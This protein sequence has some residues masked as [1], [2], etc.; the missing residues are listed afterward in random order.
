MNRDITIIATTFYR[1]DD[2]RAYRHMRRTLNSWEQN[3]VMGPEGDCNLHIADDGSAEEWSSPVTWM[4]GRV[5][6]SRQERR[7]VGASLN[8][9]IRQLKTDIFAYFVDDWTLDRELDITPMIDLLNRDEN[10]GMIRLG[11][12]HPDL[13]GTV[14]IYRPEGW[15]LLLERHHY[16]YGMRP[17]LYHRRF[18]E[19]YGLFKEGCSAN[20]CESAKNADFKADPYGP[21]ILYW[22]HD[23]WSNDYEKPSYADLTPSKG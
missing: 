1:A 20:E 12:P 18:I 9:G 16:A 21:S 19:A 5:T 22:L 7:G 15:A 10:I 3:I 2:R 17:A 23:F 11:P 14:K 8:A 13:T 6:Y 4:S